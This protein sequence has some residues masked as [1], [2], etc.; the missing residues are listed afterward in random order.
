MADVGYVGF[1]G[2]SAAPG[3]FFEDVGF[4]KIQTLHQTLHR[5]EAAPRKGLCRVCRVCRVFLI[6]SSKKNKIHKKKFLQNIL[7]EN[8]PTPYI[9]Y[10]F[11]GRNPRLARAAEDVGLN[12]GFPQ[13][14]LTL[15]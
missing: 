13:V 8:D 1:F 9:P 3:F 11:F 7:Y 15:R 2:I 12:V 6:D 5:L 10:I 14:I 4:A